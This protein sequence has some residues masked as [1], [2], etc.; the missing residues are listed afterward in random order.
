MDMVS[1]Y[2]CPLGAFLAGLVFFWM[3]KKE[4]AVGEAQQGD[5]KPV[6]KWFH[7]AG[8]YVYVPLTLACFILGILYGGI[9]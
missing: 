3:M 1:V 7:S 5:P 2:L 4:V 6:P 9:G 8:K